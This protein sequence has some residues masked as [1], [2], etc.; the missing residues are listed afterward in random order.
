[1]H[2]HPEEPIKIN[3][4]RVLHTKHGG[5]QI[6]MDKNVLTDEERKQRE[7]EDGLRR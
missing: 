7:L 6:L 4:Y 2:D 5:S 1:M 3:P